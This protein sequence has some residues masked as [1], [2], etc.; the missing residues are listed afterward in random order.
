MTAPARAAFFDVDEPL[1]RVNTGRLYVRWRRRRGEAGVRELARFGRW[2]T[3][4]SLGVLNAE[5]VTRKALEALEGLDEATFRTE[6]R[7]W[8][9]EWVRPEIAAA[10]RTEVARRREAGFAPVILSASTPHAVGPLAEE[11]GI[12]HVLCSRL[13]VQDGR[14]TGRCSEL[15]YGA[16]KLRAAARGAEAHGV[17]VGASA[18]YTDSISD[19]PML[20]AVAEPRV[21]NPDLRLRR[22]ARR[23][24]WPVERWR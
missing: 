22:A 23:K 24:G 1:V 18:F 14:F 4:Y 9:D 17:D 19:L 15:C 2:L 5:D 11:L 12:E 21:I 6:L 8:Y 10:G 3:W 20:E 13:E 16:G 7:G